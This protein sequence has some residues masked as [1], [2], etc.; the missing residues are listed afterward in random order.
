MRTTLGFAVAFFFLIPSATAQQVPIVNAGFEGPT[1]GTL[2][3]GWVP[4]VGTMYVT[5][6]L[7]TAGDP[8]VAF[9]GARFVT[10][11]WQ[12]TGATSSPFSAAQSMHIRQDVDLSPWA[13]QI[14]GGSRGLDMTFAY[15]AA[16]SNDALTVALE[17]FD[18]AG[19]SL[20]V[21]AAF[22]SV[23]NGTSA[24][25]WS[26]AALRAAVPV[27][28]RSVRIELI[29]DR[30]GS[31]GSARNVSVDGLSMSLGA[32]V[33]RDRVDG[34]LIQCNPNGAWSWYQDERAV[35]DLQRGEVLVGSIANRGGLGGQAA[36]GLV[37]VCHLDIQR[38]TRRI[39][40][41]DDIESY[42]AG[43]DHNVPA[44][45]VTR[46][47]DLLAFYAGHN[48]LNGVTDDRSF[49]RVLPAGSSAWGPVRE[50]HWWPVMPANAPGSG[51]TTY[52]NLFQ[53]SAEDPDGDG[54]GRIY[55]VARTRQSPHFMHSDDGGVTW[56]YGGQLTERPAALPAGNNYVNGYYKYCSNGVDRI[57]LIATEYH[58]RDFST[59]IYH[60]YIQGGQMLDSHGNV[61]DRD[62]FDA[63]TIFNPANVPSTDDM[64]PVFVADGVRHSRAWN[65][66]V[67]RY[68]DGTI[69]ALFKTR[70][71]PFTQDPNLN[72]DDHRVWFAR[73][74]PTTQVWSS[75]EIARAGRRL[76]ASEQDYTGLGALDPSD[77]DTVF[78]ST[79]IRPTD[80]APTA[81][82]EIYR[83][84]TRDGGATWSW[85][86]LT[87]NST[88]D[89]LRPIV[90]VWDGGDTALFWWRGSYSSAVNFDAAV[91]G[92]IL[93]DGETAGITAYHDATAANTRLASGGVLAA[94]TGPAPGAA[95][96]SWHVRTGFG[97]G[98]TVLTA[99]EAGA[100]NAP[101]LRT[102]VAGLAAGAYDVAVCFWVDP[103][104]WR[105][106]AG[107]SAQ[108]LMVFRRRGA[109]SVEPSA[110]RATVRT[111]ED[112]RVLVQA[113]L[114]RV[115]L[116]PGAALDV[117]VDDADGSGAA[118]R[119]WYDGI[120][121]TPVV[122][123]AF[124]A[125]CG[126]PELALV[127]DPASPPVLGSTA[128]A[129]VPRAPTPWAWMV[130][131][132]RNDAIG[133]QSLPL[134]LDSVGMPGCSVLQSS[135]VFGLAML[136]MAGGGR[137][138]E[139]AIPPV[140]ALVDGHVY[141][142]ALALA[143][144]QN[145]AGLIVSSGVD[146]RIRAP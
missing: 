64:T 39:D 136:P 142:Q 113:H 48:N 52:S 61:I 63:A 107:L 100:E 12:A 109:Q 95:D 145:A 53:L 46:P 112:N 18:A 111:R 128:A 103:A 24:R 124:G 32:F 30:V 42:G 41:L 38:R 43:D 91:V 13:A 123:L 122:A 115:D 139:L 70:P 68:P 102:S 93:A 140:P 15:N 2:P 114:G 133:A 16:D 1:V 59:S 98:G 130:L 125:G 34:T 33:P 60:A 144:G 117:F 25:A 57:D 72:A 31:G 82:H 54:N 23:G 89:N 97:N 51:G 10:A 94:T 73:F 56:A 37:Q 105:V 120:A 126:S 4:V 141:L 44:L 119:V 69:N 62:L 6:G 29:G 27:G 137:R 116:A 87:E 35:V 49:R 110:F 67:Q 106:A 127:P 76:H 92:M 80:G 28:S 5:S 22:S 108:D 131:G 83:G 45:L 101:L 65:T 81:Q 104:D 3:S 77:P 79:E 146:W 88:Y 96:G 99:D 86:A 85:T 134:S 121:V 14:D 90:P 66:D 118:D 47:G 19:A 7:S 11:T 36:D 143:P 138:F 55:N 58:P 8:P 135:D 129:V 71:V 132:W 40:V 75:Y 17:F 74:D 84:R 21:G 20:G 50:W 9:E 78:V 26:V